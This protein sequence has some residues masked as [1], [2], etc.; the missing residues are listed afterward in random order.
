MGKTRPR[1]DEHTGAED[2]LSEDVGRKLVA[3]IVDDKHT[4]LKILLRGHSK[5]AVATY[6]EKDT[7]L[8]LLQFACIVGNVQAGKCIVPTLC[9]NNFSCNCSRVRAAS[10]GPFY[11]FKIFSIAG[12]RSRS[13]VQLALPSSCITHPAGQQ[14]S[15]GSDE[16]HGV[17]QLRCFLAWELIKTL[18]GST[19]A[20]LEASISQM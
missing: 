14:C 6:R 10:Q 8:S 12:I 4:R 3:S 15:T 5:K 16:K 19:Q 18:S 17:L 20:D 7:T 9:R 2:V 13:L 1:K 11:Q